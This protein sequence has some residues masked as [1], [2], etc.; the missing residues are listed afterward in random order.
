MRI[1][2]TVSIFSTLLCVGL[3]LS[4]SVVGYS[5]QRQK[6]AA[7]VAA[8]Q[9]MSKSAD[10]LRLKIGSILDPIEKMAER[11]SLWIGVEEPPGP[12][13]HQLRGLFIELLDLNQQ[14]SS[15][16]V[17]YDDGSY[18]MLGNALHR[19]KA[20]LQELSAPAKTAFLE[21]MIQRDGNGV[22]N[23]WR[24]LDSAGDVLSFT[25]QTETAYDPRERP[26]YKVSLTQTMPTKS[27]VYLFH[28]SQRP[29]LTVSHR[30]SSA[31]VGIDITLKQLDTFLDSEPQAELGLLA[32]L[33]EDGA[34]LA[35][36]GRPDVDDD[37]LVKI[38][39][40]LLEKPNKQASTLDKSGQRWIGQIEP[41][42]L[43][44]G[45]PETL[46]VAM[47]QN[48]IVG[49]ITK[50][51]QETLLVSFLMLL[52]SLP[53][54]WF[55]S[56]SL[57]RPLVR[58]AAEA[59]KIQHFDLDFEEHKQSNI[60]EIRQLQTSVSKM[61]TSLRLFGQYVPKALVRKLI[62]Q[63]EVPKLGGER[64]N[65][66]VLFMDM[67]N[68]TAM[69]EGLEPEDVMER[70]SSY[71]EVVTQVLLDHGATVDKYIGDAVMAFWN[72]PELTPGHMASACRAALE[73]KRLAAKETEN[74]DNAES[75][76][77]RTRIGIHS[78]EAIVGNVGSSDRMSY[79]ALGAT[80]NL[81]AR[82]EAANRE[83]RTDILVSPQMANALRDRFSFQLVARKELKG[84]HGKVPLY[85]LVGLRS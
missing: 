17:G 42:V 38:A 15:I 84:I 3:A 12:N 73:I 83:L 4:V 5:H 75:P 43:G 55:V 81:A 57:S 20:R 41:E 30:L 51:T 24:F 63:D 31:V 53:V 34:V 44:E 29:G 32:I 9:V 16:N 80:V 6:E 54:I 26:W 77:I 78:G 72:A 67:E 39:D 33:G 61:R 13:G 40:N 69:S 47:P 48:A 64:K 52:A 8:G 85:E 28:A 46:F 1:P 25:T 35:R 56:R 37:V 23:D 11:S 18:Y 7:T 58:L 79:T 21:R 36:A 59:N 2:I 10:I 22:R 50:L 76:P 71:F 62:E 82:L 60:D 49:P 45:T 68:F 14:I 65:L 70:M 27:Q 74:W 66:T 19:P